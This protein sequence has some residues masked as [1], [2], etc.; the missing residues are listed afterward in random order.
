MSAVY[1]AAFVVGAVAVLS[2]LLLTDFGHDGMPFLSLTS[3]SAALLGAGTGGL[4][5]TWAGLGAAAAGGV[6]LVSAVLL[7]ATL[8]GLVL[9]YLRK[10][11]SNS[12]RG[13]SSY[14]G[15]LGTVTL[16]VPVDGWGEVAF[17]DGDG[18]R[19]RSRAIT[20]EPATLAKS[21]RVYIADVDPDYVH[22]VAVPEH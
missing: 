3:V 1:L 4:V 12:Q 7:V 6:A 22:V 19:V 21:T 5:S 14:I 17:V 16:D 18:N 8:Q 11:Q 20:T 13:R 2:A 9:P 10:Q 15:L